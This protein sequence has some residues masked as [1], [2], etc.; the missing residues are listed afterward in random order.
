M[1]RIFDSH[2]HYDDARFD[3]GALALLSKLHNEENVLKVVNAGAGLSSTKG[4]YELSRALDF[5][6]FTAGV[7]PGEVS[8]A[9][10]VPDWLSVIEGYALDRKCVAIGE[11]GLDYYYGEDEKELQKEFFHAQLDLAKKLSK[12]VVIHDRDAHGDIMEILK[13]HPDVCG[14]FHSYSG[15]FEMAKELLR[16]GWYLS[17]NGIVTFKNARKIC[18]VLAGIRELDD[19]RY[20]ERILVETDCPYLAPVPMRGTVNHSGNI[21]YTA[22]AC[23][24]LLGMS[25]DEF[26]EFTYKNACR[27]YGIGE[28]L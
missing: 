8:G 25:E 28:D 13:S 24:E 12:P 4:S 11:I 2:A 27:F 3:G 10:D 20:L 17:V 18:E 26:L 23:A 1:S 5:V 22:K 15:S 9:K 7:H 16:R 6:Y 19:G 14:V 21:R